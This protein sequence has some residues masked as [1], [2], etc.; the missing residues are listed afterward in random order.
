M[1]KLFNYCELVPKDKLSELSR[2]RLEEELSII[3]EIIEE[4]PT[5]EQ[6]DNIHA[7]R[8][9]ILETLANPLGREE[10][11]NKEFYVVKSPRFDSNGTQLHGAF[12]LK[13]AQALMVKLALED[14]ME[15]EEPQDFDDN[16]NLDTPNSF[17][18]IVT[19]TPVPR[20]TDNED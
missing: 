18:T 9:R 13:A 4:I 2:D 11:P 6:Y 7:N 10:A 15:D 19:L 16:W 12:N 5:A 8:N 1:L 3:T 14:G 17:L 20:G